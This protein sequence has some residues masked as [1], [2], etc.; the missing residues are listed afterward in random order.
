MIGVD[1]LMSADV[2][3]EDYAGPPVQDSYTAGSVGGLRIRY[4]VDL[5]PNHTHPRVRD[6][7]AEFVR[8]LAATRQ[9]QHGL[10]EAEAA[11]LGAENGMAVKYAAQLLGGDDDD[12]E[13]L[14]PELMAQTLANVR[15]DVAAWRAIVAGAQRAVP[16]AH[17]R[18]RAA[19]AE[20][21][22]EWTTY[23]QGRAAECLERV[24]SARREIIEAVSDA[25]SVEGW[26]QTLDNDGLKAGASRAERTVG[27]SRTLAEDSVSA[28]ITAVNTGVENVQAALSGKSGQPTGPANVSA[29]APSEMGSTF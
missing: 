18:L 11:A 19:V 21:G 14:D 2:F 12:P 24:E 22:P 3:V 5:P 28:L 15:D 29:W 6:E 9:A 26:R 10:A 8:V 13:D 23:L 25:L 27:P 7:A 1:V 17:D 4:A 16:T 20:V